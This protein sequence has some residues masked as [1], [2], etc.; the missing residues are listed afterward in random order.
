MKIEKS[1]KRAIPGLAVAAALAMGLPAAYAADAAG[2]GDFK[3]G[4][5]GYV[6]GWVSV[7]LENQGEFR[8]N[9]GLHNGVG[10]PTSGAGTNAAG[11]VCTGQYGANSLANGQLGAGFGG[12]PTNN[13]AQDNTTGTASGFVPTNAGYAASD[14]SSKYKP[15]MVRGS[16]LLDGDASYMGLKFKAIAR[17]DREYK[18]DYLE[19]LEDLR[20]A[21]LSGNGSSPF[22]Y[23]DGKLNPSSIMDNYNNF[24]FR[25]F[26]VEAPIGDR[27][28]VKIGR[29]QIVW[30]ESDFFHAMDVVHGYDLSWRLFFEGENEEWRK[31][32][33]L[34]STKIRIPEADGMLAAY[35]RP[36]WDRCE[37]IGNTY[38]VNG[39]RWFFNP[40]RGY[41]LETTTKKD[42]SQ[43]NWDESN[44]G[45][46]IRWQGEAFDLSY[47]IAYL[48][49]NSAD[50]VANPNP[51]VTGAATGYKGS[52]VQGS[53]FDRIH[54]EID[55]IGVTLSGY[56]AMLDAVVSTEVAYTFNQPFNQGLGGFFGYNSDPINGAGLG[57]NLANNPCPAGSIG[58][59]GV[60]VSQ[61]VGLCGIKTKGV[62][63]SMLRFDKNLKL[64]DV[65]GTTRPSFSSIQLFD[66]WVMDWKDS[67][68]LVRL[69]AYGS[70][71]KEHNTI[72][73]AFTVL[74]YMNDKINPSFVVGFDINNG[75]GFAIPA[76]SF[77]LNDNWV[78]KVEADIFWSGGRTEN[79]Q[80]SNERSQLFGYFDKSTQLVFRLTRQF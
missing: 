32:L 7:N 9:L 76:V 33:I 63:N 77:T 1:F 23:N 30:G 53:I 2:A 65:L 27:T 11:N 51:N 70:P 73:T 80:F 42:C 6:R 43:E 79:A 78:G 38:D 72:L 46:G 69:F 68:Q 26:W 64:E 36:G 71:L 14:Y 10:C 60:N 54:P 40:Y 61:G 66:Q 16:I 12:A 55:V 67:E 49:A 29:Q 41:T 48:H 75:G 25:E 56:S 59:G 74:N 4:L 22:G 17:L 52:Q 19:E 5:S 57:A 35:I 3:F 28:T 8:P 44:I 34:I 45:G 62:I 18:T 15:S 37:D 13:N 21:N 31:P 24:D 58:A 47:S 20:K 39:G 50:P